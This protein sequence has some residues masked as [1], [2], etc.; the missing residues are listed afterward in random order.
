MT[1]VLNLFPTKHDDDASSFGTNQIADE[2]TPSGGL[3]SNPDLFGAYDEFSG[4]NDYDH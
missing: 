2:M 1:N 4:R 3:V